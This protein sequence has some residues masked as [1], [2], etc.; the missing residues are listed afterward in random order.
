MSWS[1]LQVLHQVDM[2]IGLVQSSYED[3]HG[4]IESVSVLM[5]YGFLIYSDHN[6]SLSQLRLTLLAQHDSSIMP[7][8]LS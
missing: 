6:R 2:T 7:L 3:Y 4:Q 1:E 5:I 8:L